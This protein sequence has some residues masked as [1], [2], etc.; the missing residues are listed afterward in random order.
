MIAIDIL[1][2]LA[3]IAVVFFG[4]KIWISRIKGK[5]LAELKP[6]LYSFSISLAIIWI[7][8]IFTGFIK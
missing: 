2:F 7:I 6:L 5:K 4:Y 3:A 1:N 8:N